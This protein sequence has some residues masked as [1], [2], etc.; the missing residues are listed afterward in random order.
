[1]N[2]KIR[3]RLFNSIAVGLTERED[4]ARRNTQDVRGDDCHV[5]GDRTRRMNNTSGRNI[6]VVAHGFLVNRRF[7][8][9]FCFRSNWSEISVNM[10]AVGTRTK[11][12]RTKVKVNATPRSRVTPRTRD[13]YQVRSFELLWIHTGE[14]IDN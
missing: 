5:S 7:V 4:S 2:G 10:D 12:K 11:R 8:T 3:A 1:M 13:Y 14:K 6:T 9:R